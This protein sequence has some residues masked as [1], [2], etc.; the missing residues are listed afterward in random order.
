MPGKIVA[1]VVNNP[2]ETPPI[3]VIPPRINLNGG[4]NS[5]ARHRLSFRV[6]NNR[7][8]RLSTVE[9]AFPAGAK[10]FEGSDQSFE[11]GA[12]DSGQSDDTQS[13]KARQHGIGEFIYEYTITVTLTAGAPPLFLDPQVVITNGGIGPKDG[14]K[15]ER[16]KAKK[17]AATKKS[18]R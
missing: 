16:I 9:I 14:K 13:R 15:K 10:P 1:I 17:A 8:E 18:R 3:A 7:D 4:S 2:A 6:I 11:T 5:S 12:I